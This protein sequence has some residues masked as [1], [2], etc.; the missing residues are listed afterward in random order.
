MNRGQPWFSTADGRRPSI[1]DWIAPPAILAPEQK[2]AAAFTDAAKFIFPA[3]RGAEG[4]SRL[5]SVWL[6]PN[7]RQSGTAIFR[8]RIEGHE[9][10]SWTNR[11]DRGLIRHEVAISVAGQ[12]EHHT[13]LLEV[14]TPT[15]SPRWFRVAGLG[16][17]VREQD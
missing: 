9:T 13:L 2:W 10:F 17:Q 14:E 1:L 4:A 3:P 5:L 11:L 8:Y 6:E 12:E 15:G 7:R 16:L